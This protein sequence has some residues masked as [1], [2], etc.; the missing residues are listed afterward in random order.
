[1]YS[2]PFCLFVYLWLCWAFIACLG[3]SPVVAS[4][5][6]SWLQRVGFSSWWPLVAAR[7]S[8]V[9][10]QGLSCSKAC[11]VFLGQGSDPYPLHWQADSYP[12]CH[13]GSPTFL[14]L[15]F[16]WSE[17]K[18]IHFFTPNVLAMGLSINAPFIPKF[19]ILTLM[20]GVCLFLSMNGVGFCQGLFLQCEWSCSFVLYPINMMHYCGIIKNISIWSLPWI[21]GTEFLKS[22]DISAF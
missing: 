15:F 2:S 22:L 21:P 8:D 1:M 4:G 17:E 12:L 13:Q 19:S 14:P 9:V 5:G 20:R 6:S 11:G 10:L 18:N 16:S 3:L 7:S